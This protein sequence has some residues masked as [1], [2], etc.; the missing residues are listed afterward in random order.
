MLNK[1]ELLSASPSDFIIFLKK[2]NIGKFLFVYNDKQKKLIASHSKLQPIADFF[3]EDQ[4]DFIEHEGWFCK[5][6]EE[7]DMLLGAFIHPD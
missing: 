7:Y 5:I 4:R 2:E 6:S 1:S 3:I